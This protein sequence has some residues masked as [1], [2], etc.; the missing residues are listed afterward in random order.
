MLYLQINLLLEIAEQVGAVVLIVYA[1]LYIMP[2]SLFLC[3][4][5][6]KSLLTGQ[7]VGHDT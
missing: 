1:H 4:N 3:Q 6:I 2:K 7:M 5:T